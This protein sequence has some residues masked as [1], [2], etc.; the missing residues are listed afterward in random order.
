MNLDHI[1]GE[2]KY[3]PKIK[4]LPALTASYEYSVPLVGPLNTLGLRA[5]GELGDLLGIGQMGYFFQWYKTMFPYGNQ[6]VNS[7]QFGI[8]VSGKI[9]IAW[10]EL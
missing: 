2:L 6:S 8:R 3:D 9:P 1:R 10:E 7:L 5:E 4:G